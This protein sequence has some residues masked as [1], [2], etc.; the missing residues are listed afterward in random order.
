MSNGPTILILDD[1][2]MVTES[3]EMLFEDDFN[4]LVYNKPSLA[5]EEIKSNRDIKLVISD[6]MMPGMDGCSFLYNVKKENPD[7]YRM[8]LSGYADAK[9]L[10]PSV[11]SK[12][13]Q[14][15]LTKPWDPDIL[16]TIVKSKFKNLNNTL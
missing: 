9:E 12:T 8:I 4:V 7:I 10:I 3:L 14:K 5:L 6:H 2:D 16:L 1:E 11:K 13:V 15:F